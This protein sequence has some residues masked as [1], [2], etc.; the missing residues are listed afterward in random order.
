MTNNPIFFAALAFS[1]RL[2]SVCLCDSLSHSPYVLPRLFSL[3]MVLLI[4][5][6]SPLRAR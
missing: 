5:F 6:D 1:E 3:S 4:F 2:A